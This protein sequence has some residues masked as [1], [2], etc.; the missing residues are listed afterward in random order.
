MVVRL[1]VVLALFA[2]CH[3]SPHRDGPCQCTPNNASRIKGRDN[4]PITGESL[5][6]LLRG[7]RQQVALGKN[8]RDIKVLDDE[9]RFAVSN[10][11][12]PCGEWV[13]DRMTIED[14]FPLSRLDDA[15]RAVCLGLVLRDDTTVYGS[16]RPSNC[17]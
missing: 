7:H 17:R 9:L 3:E 8:P 4:A 6:A 11:C 13:H 12:E 2:A 10:F 16:A 15:T 5:V 14:M 1:A